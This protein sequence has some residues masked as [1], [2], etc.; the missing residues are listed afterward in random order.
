VEFGSAPAHIPTP[1]GSLTMRS[2]CFGR[3]L[4]GAALAAAF[5][6]APARAAD[7]SKY[8]PDGTLFVVTFN[9]KQ[10]MDAPLVK[11]DE[12]AFKDGMSEISKALEGFGVD[13]NKDLKRI[14]IA[15]GMDFPKALVLLEGK[16][17]AD[18]V[19]GKLKEMA[20]D[21]KH[22]LT[23][24]DDD[25]LVHYKLKLP[26][27]PIPQPGLPSELLLAPLDE[28]FLAVAMEKDALSD[29]VAKMGGKKAEIKED[30]VALI[31]KIDP[32]E[33]L[34]LVVVPP[35]EMLAGGPVDGLKTVTGGVTVAEGIKTNILLSTKDADSAKSLAQMINEGLN[36]M[37]QFL[38]LIASQQPNFG[39]KEQKMAT[40]L[41]DL[42]K[43]SAGEEGVRLQGN[44][45]KEFIEKNAKKDK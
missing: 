8:L 36:Q 41:I 23:V 28:N 33:T 5:L 31:G 27:A 3:G 25:K 35:P 9:I 39:P 38:P 18:K 6:V 15:A 2:L 44:V 30:V 20:K 40:D 13:P 19:H 10:L 21:K 17:D 37:K 29:A 11:T 26:K 16:F 1:K 4:L 22:N 32:K 7:V 12:K 24:A 45:T 14:V 42:F 34:S 43:A